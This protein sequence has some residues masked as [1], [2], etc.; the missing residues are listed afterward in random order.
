MSQQPKLRRMRPYVILTGASTDPLGR[1]PRANCEFLSIRVL[2]ESFPEQS[3]R[4]LRCY[5]I[6]IT[7]FVGPEGFWTA[8]AKGIQLNE[9]NAGAPAETSGANTL[10]PDTGVGLCARLRVSASTQVN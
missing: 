3:I 9:F 4:F 6:A 8:A 10:L 1:N 5:C 2:V 7:G